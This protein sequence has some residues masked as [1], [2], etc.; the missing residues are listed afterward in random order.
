MALATL[1]SAL[2]PGSLFLLDA[3]F[4]PNLPIPSGVWGL[5]PELPRR[6]PLGL[7]L[8][9]ASHLIGSLAGPLLLALTIT[10]AFA[11][12]SR[13]ARKTPWYGQLVAGLVYAAS[14]WLLTRVG[15]G[16]WNTAA[17]YALLPWVLPTLVQPGRH[18][19]RTFLAAAALG[20]TGSVGGIFAVMAVGIGLVAERPSP[21]RVLRLGFLVTLAQ[22][23]WV[24]TGLVVAGTGSTAPLDPAGSDAF[25]SQVPGLGGVASLFA[26][27]GFWRTASQV[28]GPAD[29]ASAVIGSSFLALAVLGAS[30]LPTAWRWR[31][32]ALA[33]IGVALTLASVIPGV[34]ELSQELT[35]SPIGAP[36]REGQRFLAFTLA[37]LAP[38]IAH[39]S[40]RLAARPGRPPMAAVLALPAVAAV[41]L[42]APG[43]FGAGGRLVPVEVPA[44]WTAAG[45]AVRAEP[46]PV[47]ALPYHRYLDLPFGT[48]PRVLNPLPDY[49]GGDVLSSSDPEIGPPRRERLDPREPELAAV[50]R[51]ARR[52]EAV[53]D[54]LAGLGIRWVVVLHSADWRA[55]RSLL[56]EPGV[57]PVVGG[58]S[59]ELVAVEA[60]RAPVITDAGET[61]H[62]RAIVDPLQRL[63][64][65]P[66]ATW[67]RPWQAGWMR[68]LVAA[69]PGENGLVRL[70]AG[71]GLVW[72]W[73]TLA[74]LGAHAITVAALAWAVRPLIARHRREGSG[75][76]A[77][78]NTDA[79]R[80]RP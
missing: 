52:G 6:L 26:G 23:P 28:G 9:G 12:A 24:V 62:P 4:T 13:L 8:S 49:L 27:H 25:A 38:S 47:L 57:R 16:Q 43:L 18:P 35:R 64:P 7:V 21:I 78:G 1:G 63:D 61:L 19:R 73:P 74:V 17:P 44:E 68:G 30:A 76:D 77:G 60:W 41:V 14:P 48:R 36:W 34:A 37:W 80:R 66:E 59:L 5:G 55:Y 15:A 67:G 29:L 39:G 2:R 72:F 10:V 31:A 53:A 3:S 79:R 70:P 45:A 69:S 32:L 46:G 40:V 75:S 71:A 20:A 65:S 58:P 22:L 33:G 50:L 54:D 11:G 56:A 51:R 42:A